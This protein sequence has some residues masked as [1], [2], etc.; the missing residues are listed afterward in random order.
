[1]LVLDPEQPWLDL[2]L[3]ETLDSLAAASIRYRRAYRAASVNPSRP[4]RLASGYWR[5]WTSNPFPSSIV[6]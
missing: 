1:L 3:A 4:S 6:T 2:E 5:V